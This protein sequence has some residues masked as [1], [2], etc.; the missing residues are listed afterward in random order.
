MGWAGEEAVLE[1][2]RT[3]RVEHIGTEK[4]PPEEEDGDDSEGEEGGLGPP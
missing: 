2:L 4:V 3:T 1:F